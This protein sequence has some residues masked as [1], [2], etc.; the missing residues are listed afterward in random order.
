MFNPIS[1]ES[2]FESQN[3]QLDHRVSYFFKLNTDC[4]TVKIIQNPINFFSNQIQGIF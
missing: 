4:S 1:S 3:L 2:S